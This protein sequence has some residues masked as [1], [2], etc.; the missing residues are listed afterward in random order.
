MLLC[1]TRVIAVYSWFL[2]SF[3][4]QLFLHTAVRIVFLRHCFRLFTPT[5]KNLQWLSVASLKNS[6]FSASLQSLTTALL[7][8][9]YSVHLLICYDIYYIIVIIFRYFHFVFFFTI[10]PTRRLRMSSVL[11][12][13][14]RRLCCPLCHCVELCRVLCTG[15]S[16]SDFF[17]PLQLIYKIF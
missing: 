13:P 6:K 16:L 8:P 15:R 7:I 5:I 1:F 12:F 3:S 2:V 17:K 14:P 11:S 4:L 10:Y 9:T